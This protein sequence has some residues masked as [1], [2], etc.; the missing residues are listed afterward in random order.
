MKTNKNLAKRKQMQGNPNTENQAKSYTTKYN[1]W[2][3]IKQTNMQAKQ[4][5]MQGNPNTENQTK[6]STSN[7]INENQQKPSKM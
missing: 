2:K 1:Q 7:K 3:P 4:K 6:S 5:Q